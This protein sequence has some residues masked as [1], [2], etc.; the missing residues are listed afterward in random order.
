VSAEGQPLVPTT[1]ADHW[2]EAASGWARRQEFMRSY[3]EPVSRWLV[4]HVQP[5]PGQRLL[6]LAAG[7]G[8]TGF[9]A[10]R[11]IE[12]GGTL[13]T[14]DRSRAMLRAARARAVELRLE[15]VELRA[16]EGEW[17]DLPVASVDGVL[18]RWGY[19]LMPDPRAALRETRRVLRPGGRLALA[20]WDAVE[21]NPWAAVPGALLRERGL[22]PPP[23]PGAPGP[24]ALGDRERVASLLE[25]AGFQEIELDAIDLVQSHPGFD[26]FWE[27]LLDVSRSFHD[28]VLS[29]EQAAIDEV[30]SELGRRLEPYR[31]EGG[32][33][34]IPGRSLVAAASA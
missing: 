17:I 26:S 9:M 18:C 33:F 14:S 10:A 16:I 7:I 15:N 13:I 28:A 34:E 31:A 29:Q 24:F 22:S 20:V 8:E 6:E 32:G 3:S 25:S 30:H 12:P 21:H 27:T 11:R 19:M 5:R 2:D 4:E 23:E 1:S